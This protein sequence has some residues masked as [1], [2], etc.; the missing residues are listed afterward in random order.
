MGRA[1][2]SQAALPGG[3]LV[4]FYFDITAIGALCSR[5]LLHAVQVRVGFGHRQFQRCARARKS[6]EI[7]FP[8]RSTIARLSIYLFSSSSSSSQDSSCVL[9]CVVL[10]K[11][12]LGIGLFLRSLILLLIKQGVDFYIRLLTVDSAETQSGLEPS[13]KGQ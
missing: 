6:M 12:L 3:C 4:Y 5:G 7:P 8:A 10:Q 11:I 13:V 9:F 1:A 2:S